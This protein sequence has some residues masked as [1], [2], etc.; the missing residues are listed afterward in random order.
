[1]L[2]FFYIFLLAISFF[3]NSKGWQSLDECFPKYPFNIS[4]IYYHPGHAGQ[5]G[6]IIRSIEEYPH[7]AALGWTQQNTNDIEWRCGGFLISDDTIITAAHCTFDRNRVAP[8]IVRLGGINDHREYVN[9]DVVS[10]RNST[11]VIISNEFVLTSVQALMNKRPMN[12]ISLGKPYTIERI[13]NHPKFN[14]NL[15]YK[16]DI[17][18]L[19]FKDRIDYSNRSSE[20][21]QYFPFCV[22]SNIAYE[23]IYIDG[24]IFYDEGIQKKPFETKFKACTEIMDFDFLDIDPNNFFCFEGEKYLQVPNYCNIPLGSPIFMLKPHYEGPI[25]EFGI[26][27]GRHTTRP[28]IIGFVA[29]NKD[30]GPILATKVSAYKNWIENIVYNSGNHK[31]IFYDPDSQTYVNI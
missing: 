31:I 1:M 20:E 11:G 17:A 3:P 29:Y 26:E 5:N 10:Q 15:P 25:I 24:K 23:R 19:K 22:P 7:A 6:Y 2:A 16:N 30:C 12:E 21:P 14:P 8:D 18:L 28:S 9:F 13:Y 4:T 27:N